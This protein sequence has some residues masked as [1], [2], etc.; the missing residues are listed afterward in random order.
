MPG[1]SAACTC[2][3]GGPGAQVCTSDGESF[4]AC[5]CEG[6]DGESDGDSEPSTGPDTTS[7]VSPVTES[8]GTTTDGTPPGGTTTDG[9]TTDGTTH[10]TTGEETDGTTTPDETA[11]DSE[12]M[13]CE[14][15]G[16]EPNED[17]ASAVKQ[18]DQICNTTPGVLDGVLDGGGDVDWFRYHTVDETGCGFGTPT[19]NL[20]VLADQ[21]VRM[22]AF[23]DCDQG[24][25][26]LKCATTATG[27]DLPDGLPGCCTTSGAL[28]FDLNCMNSMS[29]SANVYVRLD[30]AS[31]DAC[32][33]Y[34]VT[35][36]WGPV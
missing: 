21:G 31:A 13:G 15:P 11:G 8:T 32:V 17:K 10:G 23:V 28:N 2:S 33:A 29:E 27:M 26:D 16:P 36:T 14:D 7:G 30:E 1:A 19:S 12:A 4:G 5:A 20:V 25:A 9:T 3:D 6:G 22:C 24:N 18:A 35:Y 34:N